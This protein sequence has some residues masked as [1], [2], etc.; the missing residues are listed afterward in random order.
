MTPNRNDDRWLWIS[1]LVTV[2]LGCSWDALPHRS[3]GSRL[4]R[5][6]L[7]GAGFQAIDLPLLPR[8]RES[9]GG[10]SALKRG[11]SLNGEGYVVLAVDG[12]QER[13]AIHAPETCLR[14]SGWEIRSRR[15][16]PLPH[17]I[18]EEVELVRGSEVRRALYWYSDGSARHASFFRCRLES[19]VNR[20]T[21]GYLGGDT[22][23]LVVLSRVGETP[24]WQKLLATIP[25]LTQL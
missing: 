20:F 14:G 23:L 4:N 22:V 5:I 3:P 12:G 2:L 10:A 24:D 16:V 9:L 1:L 25:A 11:F 15:P 21:R 7:T 19:A 17:G 13:H 6:P 18:G 8:E